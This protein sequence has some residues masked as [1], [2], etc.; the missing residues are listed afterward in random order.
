VPETPEDEVA[1]LC[2]E[3]AV[4]GGITLLRLAHLNRAKRLSNGAASSS[5]GA[6]HPAQGGDAAAAP[7][8]TAGGAACMP[9]RQQGAARPASVPAV[10]AAETRLIACVAGG[11]APPLCSG[12]PDQTGR[13]PDAMADMVACSP[14][15]GAGCGSS[16]YGSDIMAA[17][18]SIERKA[19]DA[20][21][22]GRCTPAAEASI[23]AAA[24]AAPAVPAGGHAASNSCSGAPQQR[25]GANLHH[26]H[27]RS[28][29]IL[30]HVQQD[31]AKPLA[32]SQHPLPSPG[33][34]T[35][36]SP[37]KLKRTSP[38]EH[39]QEAAPY[40][41]HLHQRSN[42]QSS[43]GL[44]QLALAAAPLGTCIVL[45]SSRMDMPDGPHQDGVDS[46]NQQGGGMHPQGAAGPPRDSGGAGFSF[47][48]ASALLA[49]STL[50]APAAGGGAPPAAAGGGSG[51]TPATTTAVTP[52]SAGFWASLERVEREHLGEEAGSRQAMQQVC[53]EDAM[54]HVSRVC[55]H[56]HAT[57]A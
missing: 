34:G 9:P 1:Q 45:K 8:Q 32:R 55:H 19:F 4:K 11:D 14:I 3:A 36:K 29:L 39:V 22:V 21:L 16:Q 53:D 33:A 56:M 15:E 2:A 27:L 18:D 54:W 50:Q 44:P 24:A 52:G 40:N 38:T 35:K 47:V 31:A 57:Y 42:G 37:L 12:A 25:G 5:G 41:H 28:G 30:H 6:G 43:T 51:T 10:T 13:V 17:I 20:G 26:H 7:E 49:P 23:A 46:S 48:T